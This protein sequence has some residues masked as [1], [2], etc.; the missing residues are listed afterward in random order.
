MEIV[1]DANVLFRTLISGGKILE[2]FFN[3]DLVLVAPLKLKEEFLRNRKEIFKK[4]RLSKI[5]FDELVD[6]IFS[7]VNWFGEES[8]NSF[9]ADAKKLLKKHEKDV[10]F[11]ALSFMKKTKVWTYEKLLFDIGAGISTKDI[12]EKLEEMRN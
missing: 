3:K 11:V 1:L 7:Q 5:E 10:D 4:T 8:Y 6:L 12:S 9:I 2:L